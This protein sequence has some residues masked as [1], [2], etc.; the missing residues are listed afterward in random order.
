MLVASVLNYI[1]EGIKMDEQ[2]Q[3]AIGLTSS[4]LAVAFVILTNCLKNNDLLLMIGCTAMAGV[5]DLALGCPR[6]ADFR[7]LG[8]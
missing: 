8:I 4:G 7:A 3:Q 1:G 2:T 5:Q 6:G